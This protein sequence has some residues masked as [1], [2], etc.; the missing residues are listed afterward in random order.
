MS[1]IISRGFA[2]VQILIK[3]A[4]GFAEVKLLKNTKHSE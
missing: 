2:D 1:F 4:R 3:W